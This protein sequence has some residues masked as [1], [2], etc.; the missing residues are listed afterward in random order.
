MVRRT[1]L[2][3]F[4]SGCILCGMPL[5]SLPIQKFKSDVL[6]AIAH[7]PLQL[8]VLLACHSAGSAGRVRIGIW[9]FLSSMF[10]KMKL[11]QKV[12]Y[13]P[14]HNL[15]SDHANMSSVKWL[16]VDILSLIH[17]IH[18][19]VD[20]LHIS[21][22]SGSHLV[23]I[24]YLVHHTLRKW[25]VNHPFV[26]GSYRCAIESFPFAR[27]ELF[28]AITPISVASAID[29][30]Q[31][32]EYCRASLHLTPTVVNGRTTARQTKRSDNKK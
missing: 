19:P 17:C 20:R 22:S 24:L 3:F 21:T 26:N 16:A 7:L 25:L 4:T 13:Q 27:S 11:V 29:I 6:N 32:Y 31:D 9:S 18:L 8:G 28:E 10:R 2:M 30:V 23:S 15:Q 14:M 1:V 5:P 12:P